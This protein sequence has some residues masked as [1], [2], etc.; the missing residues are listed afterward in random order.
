MEDPK[1]IEDL[2]ESLRLFLK[3]KRKKV[4]KKH[5]SWAREDLYNELLPVLALFPA[6][7]S[8]ASTEK[9]IDLWPINEVLAKEKKL[10]L[11]RVE[12]DEIVPYFVTDIENGLKLS[13]RKIL[14]P[15]PAR[16]ERADLGVIHCILV[17]GLGFDS[18]KHRLG[19]GMGF[20]DRLLVK[21]P[22]TPAF[23]IGFKEQLISDRL[24]IKNHDRRLT[25]LYLY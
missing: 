5:R 7:L 18:L 22:H 1:T 8:F 21:L 23:G 6:V 14:E 3:E 13:K 4:T 16:C 19:H 24:P 12:G 20:Y 10:L 15:D 11:P 17:P 25:R 9:E 2:K